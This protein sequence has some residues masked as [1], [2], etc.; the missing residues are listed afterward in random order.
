MDVLERFIE[1]ILE[2]KDSYH[3]IR[4]KASDLFRAYKGWAK[5]NNQYGDMN[6]TVFGREMA[7]KFEKTKVNGGIY[8]LDI[9]IKEEF[10]R[11][12]TNYR[13]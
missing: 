7:K 11:Y 5:E 10:E 1:E 3:N 8:Y 12:L 4:T 13:I 2:K 6:S 9:K